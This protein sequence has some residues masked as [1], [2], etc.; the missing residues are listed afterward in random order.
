MLLWDSLCEWS[1]P[2]LV[3]LRPTSYINPSP[4]STSMSFF[5]HQLSR[6]V[7]LCSTF[8]DQPF[9]A[10]PLQIPCPTVPTFSNHI[11]W[12]QNCLPISQCP[13]ELSLSNIRLRF[14]TII[15]ARLGV[16]ISLNAYSCARSSPRPTGT[17][18]R[19]KLKLLVLY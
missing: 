17:L 16:A 10:W 9:F 13:A 4:F 8:I 15:S 19:A 3:F 12:S 5:P 7:C 2:Q 14:L 6:H 11:P 1:G 18:G